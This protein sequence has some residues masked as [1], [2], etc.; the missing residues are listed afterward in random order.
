MSSLLSQS[1]LSNLLLANT[2]PV[3]FSPMSLGD[4]ICTYL[5]NQGL[6][7]NFSGAGTVNLFSTLLPDQPDLAVAI[8]ERG[9]LPSVM[10]LTGNSPVVN[11]SHLERPVF[12]VF[13]RSGMTGYLAGN[14]MMQNVHGALQGIVETQINAGGALF[15]LIASLQSPMYLGRDIRERHQ[16]SQ[17]YEVWWENDQWA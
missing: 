15:H 13:M 10:W 1:S 2:T 14:Q 4:E 17:N 9:G 12:Q 5:E 11:E 16:W 6:G 3:V 7:L 8:I